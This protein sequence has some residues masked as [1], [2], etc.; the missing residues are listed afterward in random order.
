VGITVFEE[1]YC[2]TY[3]VPR[4]GMPPAHLTLFEHGPTI[5]CMSSAEV[6]TY[7]ADVEEPKRSTLQRLRQ[8]I[9]EVVPEFEEGISYGVPAFRLRGK[10]IAGFA[11]FKNHLS[12]LPHSGS[13]FPVLRDELSAYKTSSGALQF[14]ID[15]PL[16]KPLVENL[17]R[18]RIAQA[19]PD[20]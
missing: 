19:F 15:S 3:P 1:P 16:S 4:V 8:T 20:E 2:F 7:L 12:Y 6:D 14:P 17:V 9:L 5:G 13:V 10:V 18:V 11:A